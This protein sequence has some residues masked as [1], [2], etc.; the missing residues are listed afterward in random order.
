[1]NSTNPL[2]SP[3]TNKDQAVPFDQIKVDPTS[4]VI[5]TLTKYVT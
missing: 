3:F 4:S 1:M 5:R 2:L